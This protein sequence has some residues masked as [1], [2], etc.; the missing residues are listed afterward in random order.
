[1]YLELQIRNVPPCHRFFIIHAVSHWY[2]F[3]TSWISSIVPRSSNQ[4]RWAAPY[5]LRH[6][7]LWCAAPFPGWRAMGYRWWSCRLASLSS[8]GSHRW[9][10]AVA[11]GVLVVILLDVILIVHP[12]LYDVRCF[13]VNHPLYILFSRKASFDAVYHLFSLLQGPCSFDQWDPFFAEALPFY[14]C[15]YVS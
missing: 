12:L 13:N 6:W 7:A 9:S 3:W 10:D 2:P 8:G 5:T 4:W 1:M 11:W 14:K 15:M